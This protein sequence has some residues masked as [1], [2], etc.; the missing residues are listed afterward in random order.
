MK[1]FL[2]SNATKEYYANEGR[3]SATRE[4]ALDCGTALKAEEI[5]K[6]DQLTG[7]SVI[8][9]FLTGRETVVMPL[10]ARII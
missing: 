1:V 4:H 9:T 8:V 3:W 2:Q 5:A 10:T 7:V 6:R